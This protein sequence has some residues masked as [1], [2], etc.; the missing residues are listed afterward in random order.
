MQVMVLVVVVVDLVV[1]V[2]DGVVV[3]IVA[4][5]VVV[6][7]VVGLNVVVHSSTSGSFGPKVTSQ[8]EVDI[9]E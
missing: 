6:S 1:G 2:V 7:N 4:G 9:F 8:F 5:V 3:V